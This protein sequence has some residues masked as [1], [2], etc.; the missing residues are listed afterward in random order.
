VEIDARMIPTGKRIPY[1][2]FQDERLLG[3]TQLDTC[4]AA[5]PTESIVRAK[6][7]APGHALNIEAPRDRFPFFQV[8]TPPAR[9][10]IAV[11]PMTC[12]VD[13]FHNREGLVELPPG[14]LWTVSFKIAHERGF[15]EKDAE[16]DPKP[17]MFE[18]GLSEEAPNVVAFRHARTIL[19]DSSTGS[20]TALGSASR[21]NKHDVSAKPCASSATYA[22]TSF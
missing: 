10:S 6:L 11:E 7:R 18:L 17:Q 3:D 20:S 16:G 8:F 19:G 12:N 5:L 1:V 13:A 2:D 22:S 15:G 21:H 14:E 4:F 9:N